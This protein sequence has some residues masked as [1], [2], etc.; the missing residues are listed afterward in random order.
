MSRLKKKKPPV[1]M[2]TSLLDM[3][4]IILIF[5]I[6]SFE[7][8]SFEFRLN[9]DLTLPE[10]NARA[11]LQPAV[12]LAI[13]GDDVVVGEEVI[14]RMSEGFFQD[15]QI[16]DDALPPLVERLR[17][18]YEAKWGE[19]APPQLDLEGQPQEPIIVVQADRQIEYRALFL[20][21]R[22]AAT[23]GFFKYRLAVIRS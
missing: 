5:L 17:E 23:A 21:L 19:G 4:T 8:E 11:Q 9:P 3:F 12:N 7:A 13:T 6:V 20:I 1:L 14:V 18:E 2:L 10:S 22:S 15:G 16:E